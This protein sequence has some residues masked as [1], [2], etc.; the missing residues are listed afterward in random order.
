MLPKYAEG[1]ILVPD[2]ISQRKKDYMGQR[3]KKHKPTKKLYQ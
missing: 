2:K 3:D 1:V